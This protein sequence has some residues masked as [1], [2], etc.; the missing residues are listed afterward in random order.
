MMDTNI[1]IDLKKNQHSQVQARF[2]KI[3]WVMR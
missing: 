3:L 1:C 2:A